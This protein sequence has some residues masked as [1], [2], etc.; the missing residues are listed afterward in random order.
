MLI[1][2]GGTVAAVAAGAAG[3]GVEVS[4]FM[5][6]A[7][8]LATPGLVEIVMVAGV[9]RVDEVSVFCMLVVQGI[10]D[11]VLIA[12]KLERRAVATQTRTACDTNKLLRTS[13]CSTAEREWESS[14]R[15][16]GGFTSA[17][18][19]QISFLTNLAKRQ[20]LTTPQL[21]QRVA[22]IVGR[23]V[24]RR[25]SDGPANHLRR[26]ARCSGSR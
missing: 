19:K 25:F 5:R 18:N 23:E 11:V 10:V 2:G 6:V 16:R 17:S 14:E 4:P 24:G 26:N 9:S 8:R 7:L 22:E 1:T 20:G 15:Q 3:Q 13:Y 21:Q 12:D